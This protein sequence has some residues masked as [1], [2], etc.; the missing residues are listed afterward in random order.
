MFTRARNAI[1]AV[2]CRQRPP[3]TLIEFASRIEADAAGLRDQSQPLSPAR[4]SAAVS[5]LSQ[6]C[7]HLV[8]ATEVWGGWLG[9][10][11][12]E[13]FAVGSAQVAVVDARQHVRALRA[14]LCSSR[15]DAGALSVSLAE[16]ARHNGRAGATS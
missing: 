7:D 8:D 5:D 6:A 10:E 9:C 1:A 15:D 16:L 2:T 13:V 12:N 14:D 11:A 4:L 3:R